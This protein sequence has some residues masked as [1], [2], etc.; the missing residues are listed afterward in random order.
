M[1]KKTA[2]HL[3][4]AMSLIF[5][6]GCI[7]DPPE[8]Y[9]DTYLEFYD[10]GTYVYFP[11]GYD[12]DPDYQDL[13]C[14]WIYWDDVHGLY[15]MTIDA[16]RADDSE[17]FVFDIT[18]FPDGMDLGS[19]DLIDYALVEYYY[20]SQTYDAVSGSVTLTYIDSVGGAIEGEFEGGFEPRVSGSDITITGGFFRALRVSEP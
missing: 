9:L 16:T 7:I 4:L 2:F 15:K 14:A 11:G 1:F 19:Y 8:D 13:I 5:T 6:A 10:G 12:P 18:G 3:I 17:Y 20:D